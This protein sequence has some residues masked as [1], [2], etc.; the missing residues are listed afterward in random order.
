MSRKSQRRYW[1]SQA[2]QVNH[3]VLTS[4]DCT[5]CPAKAGELCVNEKGNVRQHVHRARR[6]RVQR[7]LAAEAEA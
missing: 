5:M 7:V 1:A 3:P 2:L 4:V 6:R